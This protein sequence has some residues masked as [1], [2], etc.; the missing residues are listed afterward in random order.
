MINF[1]KTTFQFQVLI[2][3]LQ[4]VQSLDPSEEV[5][6]AKCAIDIM[7]VF[8]PKN[9]SVFVLVPALQNHTHLQM[10]NHRFPRSTEMKNMCSNDGIIDTKKF[11]NLTGRS[12]ED[13]K[14]VCNQ[15]FK[16]EWNCSSAIR[17]TTYSQAQDRIIE[18]VHSQEAWTVTMETLT[19]G[20]RYYYEKF[21][22]TG[23]DR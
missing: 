17:N 7:T 13:F 9:G 2:P 18:A 19:S 22:W 3:M 15:F 6:I 4:G 11:N 5:E 8:F 21:I 14:G 10:H 1:H 16:P 20:Y 12:L 23:F